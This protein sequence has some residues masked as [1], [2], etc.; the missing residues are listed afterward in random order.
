MHYRTLSY[1]VITSCFAFAAVPVS[2]ACSRVLWNT[3]GDIVT[4]ARSMD[5]EFSFEDWLFVNPRGIE[6]NGGKVED[7]ATWTSK[8]GSLDISII[9]FAQKLGYDFTADGASDGMNEKG[10]TAHM[11]YL[12]AT[13]YPEADGRPSVSFLRWVRYILDN[14]ATVEEAVEGMKGIRIAPVDIKGKILGTHMA[15]EDPS[16]DSAIF[17][18]Y[19]GKVHIHH[20]R[21]YCV[22]TNDPVYQDQIKNLKNYEGFGGDKPLPGTVSSED[23]F[24]RASYYLKYLPKTDNSETAAGNINGIIGNI[25]V[26]FGAPYGGGVYP[27][28]WTSIA[29]L[30]DK[31]YYFHWVLH[32]NVIWVD[33]DKLNFDEGQPV[34]ALNPRV[35][36]LAGDVSDLFKPADE[37]KH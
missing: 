29:D 36:T 8:Y 9:G 31:V 3:N 6:M 24:V 28:W 10:L 37:V 20:G 18:V 25:E 16:G 30:T 12:E 34:L 7:A 35:P 26:P 14:F 32:P 2:Q 23:R 33:L 13:Q 5:W 19:D 27:T 15:I 22:M 17:E 11:L 21:Q 4:T 1:L